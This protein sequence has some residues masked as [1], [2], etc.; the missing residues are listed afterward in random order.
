MSG[1]KAGA[2]F[3]TLG[4]KN[5]MAKGL[6][7]AGQMLR[8]FGKLAA[9][10]TLV[11]AAGFAGLTA[12]AIKAASAFGTMG[13]EFATASKRVGVS[14]ETLSKLE[15]A[16]SNSGADLEALTDMYEELN[17]RL[18]EAAT[19]GTGALFDTFQ[20][21]GMSVEDFQKLDPME[22]LLKLSEVTK[23]MDRFQKQF[24]LDEIMGGAAIKM[25]PLIE[26]GPEGIR[27]LTDEAENLG[28]VMDDKT[29]AAAL[30][31]SKALG[32]LQSRAIGI[33]RRIMTAF[34]PM[35]EELVLQVQD[36]A[37]RF[38]E[39][40]GIV[41][42]LLADGEWIQGMEL[43]MAKV[44]LSV[45]E[46]LDGIGQGWSDFFSFLWQGF[47]DT[48]NTVRNA[49]FE[50]IGWI[51]DLALTGVQLFGEWFGMTDV[52]D[53]A[54]RTRKFVAELKDDIIEA[55]NVQAEAYKSGFDLEA[56]RAD[57][58][59]KEAAAQK[60]LE[61]NARRKAEEASSEITESEP[62][63]MM[64]ETKTTTSAKGSFAA[65]S[66]GFSGESAVVKQNT[67]ANQRTADNTEKLLNKRGGAAFT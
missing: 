32:D 25:M 2:V 40:F 3:V 37:N 16:A 47:I 58:A 63:Q 10:T 65:I 18:G 34:A 39:T 59:A 56:A 20:R 7:K 23:D 22:Q 45:L 21:L 19:E 62:F 35:I 49:L 53:W 12:A 44:R 28:L 43:G 5:Q 29:A 15:H 31:V 64:N 67:E 60:T 38:E 57:V 9:K 36:I 46:G 14:V 17:V 11:A 26:K 30:T 66:S 33:F 13:K 24:V 41:F 42:D 27:A 4:I 8:S 55:N 50:L 48:L 54:K 61:E 6:K 51:A 1:T 52:E